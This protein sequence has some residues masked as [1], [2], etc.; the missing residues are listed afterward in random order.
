MGSRCLLQNTVMGKL[1]MS[2]LYDLITELSQEIISWMGEV[3][4]K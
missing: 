3:Q 2:T 4:K 1:L